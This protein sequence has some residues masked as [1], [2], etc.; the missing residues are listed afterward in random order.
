MSLDGRRVWGGYLAADNYIEVARLAQAVLSVGRFTRVTVNSG[1]WDNE[2]EARTGE[3]LTDFTVSDPIDGDHRW[4]FSFGH[5]GWHTGVH[6]SARTQAEAAA[7]V[8]PVI[9]SITDREVL[10]KSYAPAGHRLYWLWVLEAG[11]Y[12]IDLAVNR[13]A[14]RP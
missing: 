11:A 4:G 8:D 5:G 14:V 1:L 3:T 10:V 12:A 2:P 6:T 7:G 13:Q 9:V